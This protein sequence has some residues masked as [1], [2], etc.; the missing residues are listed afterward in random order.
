MDNLL[1]SSPICLLSKASKTKSWL[2]HRKLSHL[3]FEYITSLA[4][5]GLVRG[6]P[7]L[8]YQKDHLCSACGRSKSKKHSHKPKAEDSIQEKLY[9]MHMDLCRPIR[10]QS[11]N[12]RKYIM[13]IVDDYSRFTWVKILRSKDEVS[14]FAEAVAMACYT[15]NR[16]LIRKRHNKTPYKLLHDRK[17]D[18]SY[19]HVFGS[20]CYPT[21]DDEDLGKLKP[22]ADIGIFVGYAPTKKA[23]RIYNK[24]TRMI[25]KT[26]H[27]NFDELTSMDSEQ[28]SSGPRPK[29]L[30]PRT[31]NALSTSTLQTTPETLSLVIP[32]GIEEADH[33]I[34]VAY[35]DNNP[36]VKFLIPEPSSEEYSTQVVIPNHVKLDELGVV[37]KNKAR[38][39]VRGYRQEEGIDFEE[40]FAPVARFEDIRIF[41]AF[42][43]HMNMVIY[44]MDVK[45]AFLNGILR[46]KVYVSQPNGFVDPE[47]LNHVYKL[48]KALYGLKQAPCAWREG[49]DILL[50]SCIALTTFADADHAGCQDSR[51]D[52]CHCFML[53]QRPTLSLEAYDIRHH[54]IKEQVEN[55]VVELYFVRTEYELA[56][57]FTKPLARE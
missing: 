42:A 50:D 26:I 19:L 44:Q 25:I 21:N 55:G 37:L 2:W 11:I 13:V 3:K 38:L 57:I 22:K 29:L 40:S 4:K 47:N 23:F 30:T 48:K 49:K 32:L 6:L 5:H 18:L 54:F 9:L 56:D 7:K 53:Q 12:G 8:K 34:E 24:R 45:T 15:Q 35:M 39:V 17:P 1:L 46:E 14:G 31:I 16:S 20:V 52:V 28:F 43:A 27:V 36:F 41:I 10:I 51:K 33:E